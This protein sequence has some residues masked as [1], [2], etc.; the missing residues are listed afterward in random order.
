MK[1]LL[2]NANEHEELLLEK[3]FNR[4]KNFQK[5]VVLS[6][7]S[8]A[9]LF[10]CVPIV[11]SQPLPSD[12]WYPF[13]TEP[14]QIRIVLYVFQV[15][16]ICHIGSGFIVDFMIAITLW[17]CVVKTELLQHRISEAKNR[18]DIKQCAYQHQQLLV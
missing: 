17:F 12:G 4:Y 18:M 15:L 10:I 13:S 3:Y 1:N 2:E 5:F 11:T 16:A 14:Y 9:F 8:C 6:F 7:I